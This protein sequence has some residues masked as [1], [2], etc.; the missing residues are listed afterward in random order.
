MRFS[1]GCWMHKE[2]TEVFSPA[3][4]YFTKLEGNLV[5]ICAPTHKIRHRGDTLGGPNLT[6]RISSPA[7]E[8][9]RIRADH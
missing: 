8:I 7:P 6:I 9:L 4:V 3:E 1:N 5:K 2:G